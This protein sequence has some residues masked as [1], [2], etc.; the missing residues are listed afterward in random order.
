MSLLLHAGTFPSFWLQ[1]THHPYREAF[2]DA[3]FCQTSPYALCK[4]LVC[5]FFGIYHK[6]I[7]LISLCTRILS[8]SLSENVNCMRTETV[9]SLPAYPKPI[10][11]NTY[12]VCTGRDREKQTLT[13]LGASLGLPQTCQRRDTFSKSVPVNV[14]VVGWLGQREGK[15]C[16]PG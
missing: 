14:S 5:F 7:V 11:I 9:T 16:T 2:L 4:L 1:L 12:W 10:V 3:L 8:F 15:S 6:V 13:G